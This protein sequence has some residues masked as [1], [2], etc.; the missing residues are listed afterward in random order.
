VLT[1]LPKTCTGNFFIDD[2]VLASENVHDLRR[3]AHSI[4]SR[5]LHCA[6]FLI[7]LYRSYS[8]DVSVPQH[9]LQP[10]FFC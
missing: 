6:R 10:D 1:R 5:I 7:C 4:F 9:D 3:Y 8:V 2:E